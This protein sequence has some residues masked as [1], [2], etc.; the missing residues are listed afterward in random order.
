MA[1]RGNEWLALT[2]EATLEPD[3]PI[4]DPHHHLWVQRPEPVD[5]QRY[6]LDD[7][8]ADITSGH[9][10]RSTVFVEARSSYRSDGP[11]E[12]RSVG[13]VEFVQ[14]IADAGASDAGLSGA[15]AGPVRPAHGI[16]GRADLKLGEAVRPVL[17][18]LQEASPNRFRGIRHSVGWDP[19]PELDNREVEGCLLRDD[20]RAGARVLADMGHVLENSLYFPQL[21]DLADFARSVPQLTI[22]LNHLGGFCR[23]GP[24]AAAGPSPVADDEVTAEW[25]RGIAAVT[26]CPNIVMKL[27]GIGMPRIGFDWHQRETPVGSEE[28]ADSVAPVMHYLI[29]QFS[30]ARCMFES[31]FPVDKVSFSYHVLFN[32]FKRVSEGY[33]ASERAD[34]FHDTAARVYRLE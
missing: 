26:A 24:Y 30:P 31:N 3:I 28:I 11:E 8:V 20:Y 22:V 2:S 10:I 13:E 5:Y 33:S 6:L 32:A 25:R 23:I 7:L 18:A 19:S 12:M 9:N 34:M 4:C 17:E 16:V 14:A 1:P 27:G 29:E 21:D 15:S